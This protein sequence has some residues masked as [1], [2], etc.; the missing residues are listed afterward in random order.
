MER[1]IG[2]LIYICKTN[3]G[4][5][6]TDRYIKKLNTREYGVAFFFVILCSNFIATVLDVIMITRATK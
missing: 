2:P 4:I 1:Y 3:N 6:F 5:A